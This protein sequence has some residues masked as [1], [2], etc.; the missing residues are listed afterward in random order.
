MMS[1]F[2]IPQGMLCFAIHLW[3]L[4]F[5]CYFSLL[6]SMAPLSY[7]IKP[8]TSCLPQHIG[9]AVAEVFNLHFWNSFSF[10]SYW[11]ILISMSTHFFITFWFFFY[12]LESKS[13]SYHWYFM[14]HEQKVKSSYF[15]KVILA[16]NS[17]W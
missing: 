16:N 4:N 13:P 17:K 15:N 14:I 6:V 1:Q 8:V 9:P 5:C 11:T 12:P 3:C 10:L 2:L 7:E